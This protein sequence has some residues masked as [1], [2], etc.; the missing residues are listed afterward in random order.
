[1]GSRYNKMPSHRVVV[2]QKGVTMIIEQ[3]GECRNDILKDLKV[4]VCLLSKSKND[5]KVS[6]SYDG[7]Y[8][9]GY[10]GCGSHTHDD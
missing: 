5:R 10:D 4:K 1:M 8:T 6:V 7:K 9:N 2:T 3:N